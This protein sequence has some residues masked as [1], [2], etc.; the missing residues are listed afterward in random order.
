MVVMG[1]GIT[2]KSVGVCVARVST[3]VWFS[4]GG[5]AAAWGLIAYAIGP[6]FETGN[7]ESTIDAA[8]TTRGKLLGWPSD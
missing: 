7:C 6:A 2:G 1:V 3:A 4:D 8:V 5:Y